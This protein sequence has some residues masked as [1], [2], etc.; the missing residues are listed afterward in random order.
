MTLKEEFFIYPVFRPKMF[1]QCFALKHRES[2]AKNCRNVL[3][4][5]FLKI[6]KFETD[7]T[8]HSV[9]LKVLTSELS[10]KIRNFRNFNYCNDLTAQ[11][12]Q[13]TAKV[14]NSFFI[15]DLGGFHW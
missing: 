1:L 15:A 6:L 2:T 14:Q 13:K 11:L 9:H 4:L 3:G 7:Q 8:T 5:S 10:F 12:S